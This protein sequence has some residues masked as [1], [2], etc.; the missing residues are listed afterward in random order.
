VSALD[1]L[2]QRELAL[3]EAVGATAG[4]IEDKE[5]ELRESGAFDEGAR[6]HA[7]YLD[8][9]S[10]PSCDPEALKRATFLAW[11]DAAEPGWLTGIEDLDDAA[12]QRGFELLQQAVDDGRIDS[13]FAVM[14][15]WYCSV[16]HWYFEYGPARLL[17]YLDGLPGHAVHDAAFT[18]ADLET[19]GQMGQYWMSIARI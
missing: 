17:E 13:E 9:A 14:L 19:R 3:L 18:R 10:P 16:A 1:A 2:A 4:L 11:Y 8:L 15:G 12:I 5:R 6:I 7:A